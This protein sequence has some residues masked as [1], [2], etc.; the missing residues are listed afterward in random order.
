MDKKIVATD[1]VRIAKLIASDGVVATV[2]PVVAKAMK[3]EDL[4]KALIQ[5]GIEITLQ[6]EYR[7]YPLSAIGVPDMSKT[8]MVVKGQ[9]AAL[10][11]CDHVVEGVAEKQDTYGALLDKLSRL[12]VFL[13]TAMK[14]TVDEDDV[15]NAMFVFKADIAPALPT[16]TPNSEYMKRLVGGLTDIRLSIGAADFGKAMGQIEQS[17]PL[18]ESAVAMWKKQADGW[19]S[20]K[21]L[22]KDIR[23]SFNRDPSLTK[24]LAVGVK[25]ADLD[26]LAA[27]GPVVALQPGGDLANTIQGVITEGG[28][29]T[30]RY[31]KQDRTVRNVRM[32]PVRLVKNGEMVVGLDLDRAA[33]RAFS[34]D[35]IVEPR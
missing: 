11:Q 18:I 27:Q 24:E 12:K 22:I 19:G 20:R 33:E 9:E 8:P 3:P 1:L 21:Q 16:R 29:L 6:G 31:R 28:T 4:R 32:K 34:L 25:P 30:F 14:D 35:S 17:Q 23:D 7:F 10:R 15:D 2:V 26:E 13:K 5:N